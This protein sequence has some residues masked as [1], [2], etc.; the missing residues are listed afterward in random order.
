MKNDTNTQKK[1]IDQFPH[2]E[3]NNNKKMRKKCKGKNID[4]KLLLYT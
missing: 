1:R 2:R 3:T 4:V